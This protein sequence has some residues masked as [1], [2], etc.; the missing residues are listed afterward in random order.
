MSIDEPFHKLTDME[1]TERVREEAN[2]LFV[3]WLSNPPSLHIRD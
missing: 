2:T 1:A 3:Q